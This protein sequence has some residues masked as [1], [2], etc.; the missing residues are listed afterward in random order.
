M[1][2]IG[3]G[4]TNAGRAALEAGKPVR[5]FGGIP[6][7]TTGTRFGRDWNWGDK[8][9]ARYR[10]QEFDA[11]VSTVTIKMNSKGRESVQARLDWQS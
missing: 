8:I 4:T 11:I 7:D 2:A 10:G 9:V 1:A 5:R 3:T 6:V